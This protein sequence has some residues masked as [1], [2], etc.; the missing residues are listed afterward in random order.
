MEAAEGRVDFACEDRLAAAVRRL[1]TQAFDVVLLDLNLPDSHGIETFTRL[2]ASVP[3]IPVV[4]L[5]GLDDR[6][7]ASKAVRQGA[8]D[9]LVKSEVSPSL[10]LRAIRYAIARHQADEALA[11][12]ERLLELVFETEPECVKVLRPDGTILTMNP[13]GLRMIEAQA[14][15]QVVGRTA[16]DLVVPE[17]RA[18]FDQLIRR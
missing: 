14:L 9:Y 6:S 7:L 18:A 8:Q 17:Q 10:L 3:R 16:A 1:G 4:I 2:H 12:R 11:E 5:S 15:D 13:A